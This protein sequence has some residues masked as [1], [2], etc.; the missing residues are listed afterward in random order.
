MPD[1][2]EAIKETKKGQT[3]TRFV[4]SEEA[5]GLLPN[6]IVI[7]DD[8]ASNAKAVKYAVDDSIS[9]SGVTMNREV[10]ATLGLIPVQRTGVA[11]VEAGE[12]IPFNAP[13]KAGA[14]GR[15][16][17]AEN[18]ELSIGLAEQEAAGEG[19]LIGVDLDLHNAG[20]EVGEG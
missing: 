1:G 5:N 8:A 9:Y 2:I 11:I 10:V 20:V 6:R 13:I 7:P 16:F 19:D 4:S 18:T 15:A 3:L 17:V 14:N 12:A